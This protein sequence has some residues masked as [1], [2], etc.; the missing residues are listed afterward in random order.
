MVKDT[1]LQDARISLCRDPASLSPNPGSLLVN[2][3]ISKDASC[4]GARP[5]C[6]PVAG[7]SDAYTSSSP[8][9]FWIWVYGRGYEVAV[10]RDTRPSGGEIDATVAAV[11]PVVT[12]VSRP[13]PPGSGD[14]PRRTCA[15]AGR[16]A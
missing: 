7:Q 14:G 13:D 6:R 11:R 16:R 4:A 5:A 1:V 12:A 9:G 3:R 2:I 8:E 15:V 10:F